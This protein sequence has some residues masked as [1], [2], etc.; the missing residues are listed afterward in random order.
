MPNKPRRPAG[1]RTTGPTPGDVVVYLRENPDFLVQNPDLLSVLT[2]P[3]RSSGDKVIDMQHFMVERQRRDM[4]RMRQSYKELIAISRTNMQSQTRIHAAV[5]ALME[6][7]T[8]EHLI[9]IVTNGLVHTLGCDAVTLCA[10]GDDATLP[11][12]IKAG[13]YVLRPGRIDTLLGEGGTVLLRGDLEHGDEDLFGPAAGLVKSDA[14][15]R[16]VPSPAAPPCLLAIGSRRINHF[17]AQQATE[18]LVFLA[19]AVERSIR[20][21]LDLPRPV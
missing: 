9:D 1:D 21:W 4:E 13:V 6:A 19:N 11:R 12:A 7:R 20:N 10:E 17:H 3:S 5:L 2:P 18:L 14:L 16:L 8:F 15:V